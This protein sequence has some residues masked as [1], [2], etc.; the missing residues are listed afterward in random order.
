MRKPPGLQGVVFAA[1]FLTAP[2]AALP[3]LKCLP[4]SLRLATQPWLLRAMC[5][6]QNASDQI[7]RLIQEENPWPGQGADTRSPACAG[8]AASTATAART[9]RAASMAAAGSPGCTQGSQATGA[10]VQRYSS[11]MSGR[12]ALHSADATTA[13]RSDDSRLHARI[14]KPARHQPSVS[15]RKGMVSLR[16][17]CSDA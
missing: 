15:L 4:I 1:S 6:G 10:C 13:L 5:L 11:I 12:T 14:G 16:C 7:M 8:D 17:A 3:L 2:S 9:A